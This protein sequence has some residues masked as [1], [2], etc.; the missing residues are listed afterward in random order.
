MKIY[1]ITIDGIGLSPEHLKILANN[2]LEALQEAT[3]MANAKVVNGW[4]DAEITS[5]EFDAEVT[6]PKEWIKE[7]REEDESLKAEAEEEN[8]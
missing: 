5:V 7:Q 8:E 3:K 6:V 4:S 1:E 2:I